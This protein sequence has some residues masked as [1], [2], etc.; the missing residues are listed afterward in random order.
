MRVLY[1]FPLSHYCEKARW[2]LDHKGLDYAAKN[3][4]PGSHRIKTQLKTKQNFLPMLKDG[5]NWIADS[6]QIALY[7]DQHYPEHSILRR[8]PS[9]RKLALDIDL[10]AGKL[11]IHVRRWSLAH[12]LDVGDEPLEIMMGEKGYLRQFEKTKQTLAK[13]DGATKLSIKPRKSCPVTSG[14][15]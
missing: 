15:G 14:D 2:L 11:G 10:L 6:T 3:L 7:L 9:L 12:A 4:T 13:K 5:A 8:D 1:Q